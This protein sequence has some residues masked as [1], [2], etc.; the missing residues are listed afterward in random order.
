M[1]LPIALIERLELE[2][3]RSIHTVYSFEDISPKSLEPFRAFAEWEIPENVVIYSGIPAKMGKSI[4]AKISEYPAPCRRQAGI[5]IRPI[6]TV[7]EKAGR[8]YSPLIKHFSQ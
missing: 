8:F 3:L 1:K 6:Q 7:C 4:T 2:N 5:L